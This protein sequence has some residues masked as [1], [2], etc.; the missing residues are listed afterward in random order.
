MLRRKKYCLPKIVLILRSSRRGT[1]P[2]GLGSILAERDQEAMNNLE[3]ETPNV[4]LSTCERRL[5][6]GIKFAVSLKANPV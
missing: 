5:I 6:N 3:R 4:V 2:F 1:R